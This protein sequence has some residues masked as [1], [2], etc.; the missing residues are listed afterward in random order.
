MPCY[1][2]RDDKNSPF[3]EPPV[4]YMEKK[5]DSLTAMLC[6]SCQY[7]ESNMLDFPNS[8]IER[9]W[10]EHKRIDQNRIKNEMEKLKLE[11]DKMKAI[12]KLSDYERNLLGIK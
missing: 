4:D 2:A 1:D 9:W 11:E 3:Y 6:L 7:L 12:A 8:E 10:T 5:I